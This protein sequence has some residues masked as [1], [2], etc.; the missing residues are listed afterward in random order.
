MWHQAD[1]PK[2]NKFPNK[3]SIKNPTN[4]SQYQIVDID[5]ICMSLLST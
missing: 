4:A 5:K 1:E 3:N 2:E